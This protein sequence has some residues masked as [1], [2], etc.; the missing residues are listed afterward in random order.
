ME[1]EKSPEL[2]KCQSA[3]KSLL[4]DNI[5]DF[6]LFGSLVKGGRPRDIDIAVIFRGEADAKIKIDI[7]E[8]L[9][10]PADVQFLEVKSIY[11]SL[12]L[13][14]IKEGYSVAKEKYLFELYH[15][16][17]QV[18]YKY[19]LAELNAVQKVQFERGIKKVLSGT[20][21]FIARSVV[22]VPIHLKNRMREFLKQ[23]KVYYECQEYE[24]LPTLRKEEV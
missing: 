1:L 8:V 11:S 2:L 21:Q 7:Q 6:I 23:W 16:V 17:P 15:M 20:G 12:W 4:K 14:L 24:L 3:L 19:S 9:S 18:L 22:L 13:T 10:K 5:V